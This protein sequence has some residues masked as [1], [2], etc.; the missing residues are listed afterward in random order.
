MCF[1]ND[2]RQ[3]TEIHLVPSQFGYN[4]SLLTKSQAGD[5]EKQIDWRMWKKFKKLPAAL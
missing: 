5:V 1:E 2:N 3:F 4:I